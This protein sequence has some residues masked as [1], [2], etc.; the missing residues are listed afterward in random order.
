MTFRCMVKKFVRKSARFRTN[1]WSRPLLEEYVL[2]KSSERGMILEMAVSVSVNIWTSL[3]SYAGSVCRPAIS[4]KHLRV[5]LRKSGTSR[6]RLRKV[7]IR[8]WP[9]G[10]VSKM[11]PRGIQFRKRSKVSRV[12]LMRAASV[13]VRRTSE[14]S[15]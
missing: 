14:Q 4:V 13:A 3:S 7:S 5:M 8:L 9:L 10:G 11:Y 2:F 6:N 12:A 1:S 15:W